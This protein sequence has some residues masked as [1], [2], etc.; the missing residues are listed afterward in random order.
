MVVSALKIMHVWLELNIFELKTKL[1]YFL[2]SVQGGQLTQEQIQQIP[3]FGPNA[4]PPVFDKVFSNARFAQGGVASF[5]GRI[6]GK[7]QPT[8]SWTR[9]GAPLVSSQKHRLSYNETTGDVTLQVFLFFPVFV[10]IVIWVVSLLDISNWPGWRRWIRLHRHKPVWWGSVLR[11]HFP[12]R[13][14]DA[15]EVLAK[16]IWEND[17]L[18]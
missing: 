13:H 18:L 1:I 3:G 17:D 15:P 16:P 14:A 11:I 12:R 9:K 6:T 2:F 4:S 8:V 5:E 7:P 10:L